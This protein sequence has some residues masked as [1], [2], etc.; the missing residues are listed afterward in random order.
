MSGRRLLVLCG[1]MF[2][3]APALS[4]A[5][6]DHAWLRSASVPPAAVTAALQRIVALPPPDAAGEARALLAERD[7]FSAAGRSGADFLI[8]AA[9]ERG[10]DTAQAKTAYASVVENSAGSDLAVSADVRLKLLD[11]P[12]DNVGARETFFSALANEPGRDGWFLVGDEWAR[13]S[14]VRAALQ[15]VVNLRSDRLSFRFFNFLRSWSTFPAPYAYLFILLTLGIGVKVLA[16]PL[17]IRAAFQAVRM[18]RLRPEIQAI[19]MVHGTEPMEAQ[20]QIYALT[21]ARGLSFAPGCAVAVL[22]LIFVVWGLLTLRDYAPQMALD[23]ARFWSV[24]DVTKPSNLILVIWLGLS[25][26]QGLS[27][28]K[29]Q[30][31]N[32]GQSVAVG[33]FGG[34]TFM[35][36]AWYWDWPAYVLIFWGLLGLMGLLIS[37]VLRALCRLGGA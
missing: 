31:M 13:T 17:Q 21:Q 5:A 22:D 33:L 8:A 28:G 29:L 12:R 9:L 36:V 1:A 3:V 34:A 26:F 4:W 20:R 2:A 16:L 14:S 10:G 37:L 30:G 23:G 19:Q 11:I 35:G 18:E 24:A 25:L 7:G 15:E 32:V 6:E 27:A